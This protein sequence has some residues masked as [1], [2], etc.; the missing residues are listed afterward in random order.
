MNITTLRQIQELPQDAVFGLINDSTKECYISHTTN[1]KARI[2]LI[3]TDN[4]FILKDDTR[5][6]VFVDGI[7]DLKYKLMYAQY[8]LDKYI[9]CG[10][11]NIGVVRGYINYRVSVQ[12][13]DLLNEALV[14]LI[15]KRKDKQVV[16]V[17][18]T[19]EEANSFV[20]Q[21][22]VKGALVQPVYAINGRTRKWVYKR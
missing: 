5:L 20:E 8:F 3:L 18:K 6:I 13:S 22:Y 19:V 11:K 17:F 21:Y 1:L 9:R 7:Q 15:N 16:G 2:G 4:E 14:V 12:Y 10:F